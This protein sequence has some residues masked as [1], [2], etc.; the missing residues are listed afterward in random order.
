MNKQYYIY[1]DKSGDVI[2]A[3]ISLEDDKL[4]YALEH[5]VH[6]SPTGFEFGYEGSGPAELAR[7]ILWD[8]LGEEPMPGL[9]QEFKRQFIAP[10]K[11]EF[12]IISDYSIQEFLK[13]RID[14]NL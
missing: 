6:H 7:S 1:R 9:Y 3:V 4:K 14:Q 12:F 10:V 5:K 13:S 11:E 2:A 8:Y